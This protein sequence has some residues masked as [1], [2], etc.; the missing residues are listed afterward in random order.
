VT[1]VKKTRRDRSEATRTKVLDGAQAEFIEKGFH[2]ATIASIAERSGVAP[3]T[4]YFVFHNKIDLMS[5][6][7]DRAVL[8]GENPTAPEESQWWRDAFAEPD[9]SEAIRIFVRGSAP[10]FAR[11]SG[12]KTVLRAAAQTDDEL[13][14][15]WDHSE[16]LRRRAFAG[17]VAM[18][19]SKGPLRGDVETPTDLL[20]NLFG[21]TVHHEM[22][23]DRR[24]TQERFIEWLCDALPRVL[25]DAD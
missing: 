22:T 5:A 14:S 9:A 4:V 7:I 1:E 8:G 16:G 12:I 23:V 20:I 25:L 15:L 2:G 24:W 6:V 13:R 19:A 18:L 3:Q 10:I 17:F 11:A 21:D